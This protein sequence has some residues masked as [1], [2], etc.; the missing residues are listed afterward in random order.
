MDPTHDEM[1]EFLS[2]HNPDADP[3]DIAV[4]IYSFAAA[5]H[6][7][8]FTNLYRA[9]TQCGFKPGPFWTR[10]YGESQRLMAALERRYAERA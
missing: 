2:A 4:A 6:G 7:G 10:G 1:V 3:F 5:Y 9:I 8:Q